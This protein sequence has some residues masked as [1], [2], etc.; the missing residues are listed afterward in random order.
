MMPKTT[1]SGIFLIKRGN[2]GWADDELVDNE[3]GSYVDYLMYAD[4]DFKHPGLFKTSTTGLLVYR[5]QR[6]SKSF[7]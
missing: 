2:K 7:V 4:I 3:D 1:K 6:A 5:K